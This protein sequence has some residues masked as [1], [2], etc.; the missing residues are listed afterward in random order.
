MTDASQRRRQMVDRQIAARGVSDPRVLA[1]MA[2]VTREAFLPEQLQEFAYEDTPLPIE[3]DQTISQP[4]IVALMTAALELQPGDRVLEVGTG[5]G[6]AAAVL[7]KIAAHVTTVERHAVLADLARRRLA[8][9][10]FANVDVHQGDGSRGWAAN[11]PYDAIV[12]AAG[13]PEVPQP[14]LEQLAIGGRLVIP[15][16]PEIHLQELVRVRRTGANEFV[17]DRLGGVRFVPLVGEHG[18]Q[19]ASSPG[20]APAG[21]AATSAAANGPGAAIAVTPPPP[22]AAPAALSV[23]PVGTAA[24]TGKSRRG[25]AQL[26]RET[27]RPFSSIADADLGPI[28]ERIGD[29]RLVLL[30][31]ATHGT[32]EFY[33][34]RARLTRELVLRRHFNVV[35]VE[36][37]WPDAARVDRYVRHLPQSPGE[38]AASESAFTRFPTWMWR[39]HEFLEFVEWLRT[40][41]A[42]HERERQ[43]TLCGLD[44]Y[45]LYRSIAAVLRYLQDIDPEAAAVARLRYGCLTPWESDPALYGRAALTRRFAICERDVVSTLV[46]LLRH[47]LD[48]A[49]RDGERFFDALHNARLVAAAEGYYRIMY[50]GSRDSWNLRDRHMFETLQLVLA[51]HGATARAVVWEHNSHVGDAEATEMAARGEINV[52]HLARQTYGNRAFLVGFGTHRGTVAAAHEW[53]GPLQVMSV[54]PSHRD[55]YERIFHDSEVAACHLALREPERPEVRGE[56]ET[57]RL[58]RAIG[59]IYRPETELQSHYFQAVLPW[60]FDEYVWFD[61]SSAVAPIAAPARGDRE[62]P[63]TFPFGL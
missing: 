33:R 2:M 43:V 45:S 50:Y 11:A 52:G 49:E 13:G 57:P 21:S 58:E 61:E 26:I 16:G 8:E 29:A 37:D 46:A 9:L 24:V 51:T 48:Y 47:R 17:E 59:V 38:A 34:F 53:D 55:S 15:V 7:A 6:Y 40:H 25:V 36:A 28:L 62:V 31:E 41:N 39:N 12:V 4:Y 22:A 63:D 1:A 5:S 44:L 3:A 54:R 27:A 14:L 10:G 23:P 32:S 35:A 18:W 42:A 60:Q 20:R 19:T 30:G 56:L